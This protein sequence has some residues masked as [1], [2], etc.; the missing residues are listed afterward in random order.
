MSRP[1]FLADHDLNEHIV[2]G[3]GRREPAI[4]FLRA[5]DVELHERPDAEVL[6]YAA[7]NQLI[8]VSHDVNTMSAEAYT[9]IRAGAPVA[10]LLMVNQSEPVGR[11]IDDMILIWSASEMM[12][13]QNVVAFLPLTG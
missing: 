13:W 6:E 1:R 5:R 2:H 10:G 3:V 7:D 12:E 8:V 11:V 4:E 9:R